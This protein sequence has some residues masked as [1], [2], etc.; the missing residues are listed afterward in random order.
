LISSTKISLSKKFIPKV[1]VIE[2]FQSLH[3]G[4]TIPT[5]T[6]FKILPYII[7]GIKREKDDPFDLKTVVQNV[8]KTPLLHEKDK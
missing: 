3:N 2:W 7:A 6:A 8:F 4:H 5:K 1:L